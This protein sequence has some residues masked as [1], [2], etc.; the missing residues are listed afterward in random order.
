M[1]EGS[2]N[3]VITINKR[4]NLRADAKDAL[5]ALNQLMGWEE[6]NKAD[7]RQKGQGK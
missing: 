4:I 5:R 2:V 7:K 6:G 1:A 3:F